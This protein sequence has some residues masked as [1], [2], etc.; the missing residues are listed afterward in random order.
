MIGLERETILQFLD[1]AA[2]IGVKAVSFIGDGENTCNPW[3]EEAI[4]RGRNNGLDVALGTNGSL[5]TTH[6]LQTLLPQLTYIRFSI[7]AGER[8][9]Y[10]EIHGCPKDN[11]DKVCDVIQEAVHIK[12]D[13][14]LP[15][16]I[17][18]QMVL[19][20]EFGD[21]II[22]LAKLGAGFGVDYLVIKH[23]ADDEEGNIGV[24]YDQYID[25]YD[26]LKKA[27]LFS[28][29]EYSVTVKLTKIKNGKNRHYKK[30]YAAP[31]LVQMSGS[32]IIAPC[33]GLFAPKYKRFHLGNINS[34]RL[35]D[36]WKS[37]H[38]WNVMKRLATGR[39]GFNPQ[40]DCPYL[41]LQHNT[42]DILWRI[43][44]EGLKTDKPSNVSPQHI[45]FV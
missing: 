16:T 40:T 30:C 37:E 8:D 9:R 34:Q 24:R 5:L 22:P 20:P 17:G 23:C 36:I 39:E 12:R 44:E 18:L 2:E 6:M 28:T 45:N 33:A 32:G 29:N 41:C 13:K 26:T 25:L 15:V 21:Q 1:D 19:M 14:Q 35:I 4:L 38:Y 31:F 10:A 3:L 27:E 42:N 43:K 7:C 11:F